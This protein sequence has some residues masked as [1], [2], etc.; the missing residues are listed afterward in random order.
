MLQISRILLVLILPIIIIAC[1]GIPGDGYNYAGADKSAGGLAGSYGGTLNVLMVQ[2]LKL[3]MNITNDNGKWRATLDSPD[4]GAMNIPV[5]RVTVS[6]DTIR[7][8]IKML[9]AV[10]EGKIS[11]NQIKGKFTQ[12]GLGMD[13]T[14][15]RLK[16][17]YTI[18]RPQEPIKPY[19][20][21]DAEVFIT[22]SVDGIVLAGT[23]TK[24]SGGGRYPAVVLITGSGAQDRDESLLGHKPFLVLADYLTRHG[25]AVLRMDDRGFGKS[26]GVFATATSADFTRDILAAVDFLKMR[27]DVLTAKIGLIGHSEGGEIA[28]MAANRST[29]VAFIVLLAAPGITGSEINLL[30]NRAAFAGSFVDKRFLQDYLAMLKSIHT[31]IINEPDNDAARKKAI[32]EYEQY[33]AN[34]DAAKLKKYN[35]TSENMT[36]SIATFT[37]PWFRYFLEHDPALELEKLKCPVLVLNGSLDTQVDPKANLSAIRTALAK[38]QNADYEVIELPGLN[39]LFQKAKTGKAYEYGIIAETI[40]RSALDVMGTWLKKKTEK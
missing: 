38:G 4:Q 19:P 37:T 40:N 5:N 24:P 16:A 8:D 35:I 31:I 21:T 10:F 23:L 6:N 7:L 22:N 13:L 3:V 36:R 33:A 30:Q 27:N 15:G 20:Y 39:H 34:K 11:G 26:G 1:S 17:P 2:R 18:K 32:A 25:F 14:L 12:R 29:N 9:Q 28:P